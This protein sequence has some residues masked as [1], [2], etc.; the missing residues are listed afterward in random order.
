MGRDALT[1]GSKSLEEKA[2]P[3]LLGSLAVGLFIGLAL[4]QLERPPASSP[5][6]QITRGSRG[7]VF[8]GA[9]ATVAFASRIFSRI[10]R[11]L[12]EGTIKSGAKRF[13]KKADATADEI[14]SHVSE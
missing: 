14:C 6:Q 4:R 9:A 12:P 8:A 11:A 1:P 5:V 10:A 3:I 7:L 13:A 2:I